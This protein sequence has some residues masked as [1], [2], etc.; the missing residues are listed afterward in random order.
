MYNIRVEETSTKVGVYV[1]FDNVKV[2]FEDENK[3]NKFIIDLLK[4]TGRIG[5]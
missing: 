5:Y 3:A 2:Y 4:E 1:C